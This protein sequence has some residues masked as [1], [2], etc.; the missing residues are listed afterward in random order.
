[1]I[2]KIFRPLKHAY[3]FFLGKH[4]PL[5][6]ASMKYKKKFGK[7]LNWS[8]P[9]DLNE[10]INWLKFNSDTSQW[11]RLADKYAVREYV[12]ECG[13]EDILVHLYGKWDNANDID[14]DRLPD[15]FVLKTNHGY[16]TNI[17]VKDKSKLDIVKARKQLNKWASK[18]YGIAQSEPHYYGIKPCIIAEKLLVEKNSTFSSTLVDYKVWCF[19]GKPQSIWV[20]YSRTEES[21]FVAEY[22]TEWHYHPECSVFTKYYRDGGDIVPKPKNLDALLETAEKLSAGFPQVRIDFYNID[23]KIYFGEMTFTCA[24]GFMDF[25]TKECLIDKGNHIC[26]PK[27]IILGQDNSN[28][29][30]LLRQLSTGGVQVFVVL[31]G[32]TRKLFSPVLN[33]KYCKSYCLV[34]NL[35]EALRYIENNLKNINSKPIIL[36]TGDLSAELLDKHRQTLSTDFVVPGTKEQGLLTRVDDK[37]EMIKMAAPMG[38][39]LPKT[40]EYKGGS[41]ES[42]DISYPCLVKPIKHSSN[43]KGWFK[44]KICNTKQELDEVLSHL[45]KGDYYQIQ[46]YVKKECDLLIYGC[47]LKDGRIIMPG[48]MWR[49]RGGNDGDST[50][51]FIKE[52]LPGEVNKEQIQEFLESIDYYGLFS[53]EYGYCKDKAYFFEFNLRNDGT[54]HLFWQ[55][56]VNLPLIWVQDCYGVYT[57]SPE[58]IKGQHVFIDEI[59]NLGFV[60]KGVISMDQHKEDMHNAECFKYID[61]DDPKPYKAVNLKRKVYNIYSCIRGTK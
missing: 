34:D 43:S 19:N 48:T 31:L 55:A 17:I 7:E 13:L 23:G 35:E 61:S 27:V 54:S 36:P 8:N 28:T 1:M 9:Q 47:R 41:N 20:C 37:R 59:L 16:S 22:D 18:R 10:K 53:V 2:R 50:Y 49:Y 33:S 30:G 52:G 46:E 5:K 51:G 58:E 29:L 56:G 14:F 38:F 11:T 32:K 39:T 24:A 15:S 4:Y 6:L 26:I 57:G 3:Y 44:V 45:I 21:V 25:Y 60:K 40:I 42:V 12:K